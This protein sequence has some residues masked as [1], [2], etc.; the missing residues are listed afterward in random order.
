MFINQSNNGE[1]NI[2]FPSQG[3]LPWMAFKMGLA[4][5]CHCSIELE[6]RERKE[7]K[8][9]ATIR[10]EKRY[11]LIAHSPLLGSALRLDSCKLIAS[12]WTFWLLYHLYFLFTWLHTLKHCYQQD[13]ACKHTK[14]LLVDILV[15]GYRPHS[16]MEFVKNFTHPDFQAKSFTPQKC[17]ICD[18][19]FAN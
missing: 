15:P 16:D 2:E 4:L 11:M 19:F 10:S 18:S 7:E 14:I 9:K 6:R 5:K 8:Q 17:V 3:S 1:N 13:F 12:P